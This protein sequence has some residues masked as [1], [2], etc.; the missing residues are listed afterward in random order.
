MNHFLK[1]FIALNI[2]FCFQS[3]LSFA[4]KPVKVLIFSKTNG[5]RH[6]S[7][8]DG[9]LA[10][11]KLGSANG[12]VADTTENGL[13]F[14]PQNLKNYKAIIFLSPTAE[15]LNEDQKS[16]FQ[17]YIRNGGGFVG[18][19]GATDCMYKW[20]WYGKMIGA[21]FSD[22]PK[23][24]EARLNIVDKKHAST[25]MLSS[26]W[27]HTDE[28]YNFRFTNPAI[29]VLITIDEKSYSG[30]K[31]GSHHPVS[32]YHNFE[33]G[34]IFYTALGHTPENFTSDQV[35]LDHLLGGIKY[36]AKIK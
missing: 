32:W 36:A 34:R 1:L 35:F 33:G 13:L 12:F 5:Y 16:A 28:W 10:I 30:G 18:I 27:T 3:D 25:K 14:N 6:K 9:I 29:K 17:S 22:H 24:Q 21:Y 2:V 8:S 20:E 15:V 31:N 19:H 11:Q 26:T 7:I 4:K 23:I